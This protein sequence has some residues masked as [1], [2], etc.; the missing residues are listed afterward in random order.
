MEAAPAGLDPER[1]RPA[2]RRPAGGDRGPRPARVGGHL[3][4][5]GAVGARR[6]R[7]R[8]ATVTRCARSLQRL[9][10]GPLR[11]ATTRRC[12][13]TTRPRRSRRCRSRCAAVDPSRTSPV[14]SPGRM[15]VVKPGPDREVP[16]RSRRRRRD[17][18]GD[19]G[20]AQHL[21]GAVPGAGRRA[22]AASLP[23]GCE[24][25]V[26]ML[27]GVARGQVGRP[28]RARA[29]A[30][31]GRPGLRAARARPTCS[32]T[33]SDSEPAEYVVARDSPHEDAVV[34]PWAEQP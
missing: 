27:S 13:S 18:A 7:R 4:V 26:Y 20:R 12:R 24:S 15:K 3:G 1:D 10:D 17:L 32:R 16:A 11:D 9:L 5:P 34:V 31:A 21:H 2:A 23:R 30:R 33:L 22:V 6:G 14:D 25:A 19:R 28:P 8:R 29:H